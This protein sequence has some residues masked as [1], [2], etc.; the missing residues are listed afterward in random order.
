[1]RQRTWV[2]MVHLREANAAMSGGTM[3]GTILAIVATL[4]L[5][6]TARGEQSGE[7]GADELR[8]L[9]L[10]DSYTIG[11]GVTAAERWP[12]QLTRLLRDD[13]CPVAP[14]EIVARTGWTTTEL[15]AGIAEA[16]PAGP[17]DLVTLLIGVN[18][19]YRGRDIGGYEDDLGEL[20]RRA[21]VLADGDPSR[22][23]VVSIPDWGVTRFAVGR[24][25]ARIAAEIDAFNGVAHRLATA[26][27]AGWVE[28]TRLSR[29]AGDGP[30]MLADDGLHPSGRAYAAWARA[31]RAAA[32]AAACGG[33][34]GT[35][36]PRP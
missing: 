22:L 5:A 9:A 12:V 28:V 30:G 29:L 1:M 20:M 10:G 8:F 6:A 2:T 32:R 21:T 11:E 18:D 31:A 26:A 36:S 25:R 3:L 34:R 7:R 23:V 14:P 27:G 15:T 4:A 16:A 13:G 19:Q 24:D 17:Y 33:R 35:V